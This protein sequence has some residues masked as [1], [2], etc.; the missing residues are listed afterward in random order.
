L[1]AFIDARV[2][3]LKIEGLGKS[4]EYISTITQLYVQGITLYQTTPELYVQQKRE[5]MQQIESL[6]PHYR[7]LNK[8]F[9]F[10]PTVY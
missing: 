7:P 10:K 9:F 2:A 4:R 5:F 1:P 6:Q 3:A 8:G